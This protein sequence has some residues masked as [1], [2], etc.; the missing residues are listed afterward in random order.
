MQ[1][2]VI[3]R[4]AAATNAP[5]RSLR[6]SRNGSLYRPLFSEGVFSTLCRHFSYAALLQ[7]SPEFI[8]SAASRRM[9]ASLQVPRVAME[10]ADAR[11]RSSPL[12]IA[13][14]QRPA[15]PWSVHQPYPTPAC[16]IIRVV[17]NAAKQNA[18][19]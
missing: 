11:S 13:P 14:F 18:K 10:E 8:I 9:A 1:Q 6:V 15:A 17:K 2:Q 12:P 3:A 16:P 7:S 19:G 5:S 4:E